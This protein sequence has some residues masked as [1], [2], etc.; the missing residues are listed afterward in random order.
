MFVLFAWMNGRVAGEL[1]G[2]KEKGKFVVVF[3]KF[4]FGVCNFLNVLLLLA[5]ACFVYVDERESPGKAAG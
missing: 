1:T 5:S 4:S 2:R 3:C